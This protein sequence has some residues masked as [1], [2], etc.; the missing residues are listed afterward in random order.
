MTGKNWTLQA[1]YYPGLVRGLETFTQMFWK[2]NN[3][4]FTKIPSVI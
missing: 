4:W 2:N 1:E 3:K